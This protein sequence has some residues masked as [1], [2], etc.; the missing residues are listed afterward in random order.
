MYGGPV[1]S[2][3]TPDLY[4]AARYFS[5]ELKA[6]KFILP[7]M[8]TVLAACTSTATLLSSTIDLKQ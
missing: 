4:A 1:V 6:L 8:L 7:G 2:T 5:T 3:Y